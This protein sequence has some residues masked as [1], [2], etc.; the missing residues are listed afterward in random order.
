MIIGIVAVDRNLAIGKGG[1]L[2]WHYSA[3]MK[4]FKQTTMG[5]AVVM[6]RRTWST[7]KGPLPD[8]QNIVL[9]RDGNAS[10]PESVIVMKD[11]ESVLKFAKTLDSHLFVI[12]GATVYEAFLPHIERWIVT[13]VPLSVADADTFMPSN[14]LDGF[15][16]YETRQLDEG[17]RV[18]FYERSVSEARA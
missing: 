16:M 17:L 4:F 14:F 18:K 12:G 11:A 3:D 7:L 8:R 1:K 9:T 10:I 2:P 5:N 6:G 13:E 15:E